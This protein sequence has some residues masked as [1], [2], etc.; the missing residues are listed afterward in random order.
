MKLI[1]LQLR[2]ISSQLDNIKGIGNEK[3]LAL[4]KHFGSVD[5][6]ADANIEQLSQIKGIGKSFA[7]LI[8]DYFH[9]E[10]NNN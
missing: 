4:L 5:A 10:N 6:I 9:Q 7:Q 1:A 2:T 3:K 8:W